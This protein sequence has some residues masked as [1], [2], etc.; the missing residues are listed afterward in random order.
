MRMLPPAVAWVCLTL[1]ACA[2]TQRTT[3]TQ[4]PDSFPAV[5]TLED[6]RAVSPALAR[7]T[8]GPLLGDLW[9]RLGL[10]PRDRSIVTL[11]ALIRAKSSDRVAVP[12]E[13]RARQWREARRDFRDHHASRVLFQVGE[14]HVGRRDRERRLRQASNQIR[15]ASAGVGRAAAAG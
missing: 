4:R 7:Y 1:A 15:P 13:S 2:Q 3:S 12:F 8:Q 6:V 10:S 9:K 5:P 14:C 11:S